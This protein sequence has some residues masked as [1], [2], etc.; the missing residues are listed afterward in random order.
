MIEVKRLNGT[1]IFQTGLK[2]LTQSDGG[3]L[4]GVKYPITQVETLSYHL[5][6]WLERQ[7]LCGM[8]IYY[9]VAICR[10]KYNYSGRWR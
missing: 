6:R 3:K 10:S 9:F 8:P 7:N 4:V 2:R 5:L 1:I